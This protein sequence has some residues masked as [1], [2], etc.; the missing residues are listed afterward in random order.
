[1]QGHGVSLLLTGDIRPARDDSPAPE[2][3]GPERRATGPPRPVPARRA[4]DL[5]FGQRLGGRRR[6]PGLG[7]RGQA[8]KDAPA[9]GPGLGVPDR[10][11]VGLQEAEHVPGP[12]LPAV[13]RRPALTA[14]DLE[15]PA[16]TLNFSGVSHA[17]RSPQ[18]LQI[19]RRSAASVP[20]ATG[21]R[22]GAPRRPR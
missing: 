20:R 7:G 13:D 1:M 21:A 4:L 17:G 10:R 16:A 15:A 6:P 18:S 12:E 9:L 3:W 19:P 22:P 11:T 8:P 2:P 5:G 14:Q